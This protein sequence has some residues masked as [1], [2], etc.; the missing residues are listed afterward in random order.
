MRAA[1]DPWNAFRSGEPLG[2]EPLDHLAQALVW[3]PVT[4]APA[5]SRAAL[6]SRR[7]RTGAAINLPLALPFL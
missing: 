5:A 2:R 3:A 6:F 1:A 4:A 7:T